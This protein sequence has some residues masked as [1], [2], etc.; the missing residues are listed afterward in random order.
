MELRVAENEK[1]ESEKAAVPEDTSSSP[2]SA[3]TS[4][5]S[6]STD[7]LTTR[8]GDL[9]VGSEGKLLGTQEFGMFRWDCPRFSAAS[10]SEGASEPE[11]ATSPETARP[12]GFHSVLH[13]PINLLHEENQCESLK[14][15]HELIQTKFLD[16]MGKH[17]RAVPANPDFYY[18]CP[19]SFQDD[20][21]EVSCPQNKNLCCCRVIVGC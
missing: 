6:K 15:L 14:S 17:F 11:E 1:A 21:A 16:I 20:S 10:E 9:F 12:P 3:N 7:D 13:L 19:P 18:Y 2:A 5:D 4:K 8:Y